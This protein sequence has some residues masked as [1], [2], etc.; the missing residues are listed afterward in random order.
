MPTG[1][2]AEALPFLLLDCEY[3]RPAPVPPREPQILFVG[4]LP[5]TPNSVAL[6]DFL[7]T[8][9]PL[10]RNQEPAARLVVVGEGASNELRGLMHDQGVDYRG[11]V[12]DIRELYRQSRVYIA[13][14]TSG[15]GIRTKI[16]KAM[17]AGIPVVT[18][19]FAPG[20]LELEPG[21][22]LLV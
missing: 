7:R 17:A 14:V 2:R 16:V 21:P 20:G 15:G 9:W 11:Y 1:A 6:R 8:Q 10:I 18:N 19:S 4:F 5:H 3:F 22:H 12:E 13:P